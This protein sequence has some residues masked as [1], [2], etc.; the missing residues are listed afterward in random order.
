MFGAVLSVPLLRSLFHFSALH[1]GNVPLSTRA[2]ALSIAWFEFLK[3]L[4]VHLPRRATF[5]NAQ[6]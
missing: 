6:L 2:V 5:E 3:G 4:S 1:A